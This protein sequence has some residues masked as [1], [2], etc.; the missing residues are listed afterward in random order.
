VDDVRVLVL[1]VSRQT[2]RSQKCWECAIEDLLL[3]PNALESLNS[4]VPP[5][6]FE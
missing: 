5:V 4:R 6:T 3:V 2:S 1:W